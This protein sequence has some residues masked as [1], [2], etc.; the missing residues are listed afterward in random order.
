LKID[1]GKL[2]LPPLREPPVWIGPACSFLPEDKIPTDL[3]LLSVW[4]TTT[5]KTAQLDQLLEKRSKDIA[6][7][8]EGHVVLSA[9]Y[10]QRAKQRET[11]NPIGA[12]SD[13]Q[14]AYKQLEAANLAEDRL[15]VSAKYSGTIA[16][17]LNYVETLGANQFEDEPTKSR[18]AELYAT[19]GNL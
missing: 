12:I 13:Y 1:P 14:N 2:E 7:K 9:F 17:A 10:R 3:L 6:N 4:S 15:S 19:K 18:I 8:P 5:P 11:P 16:P